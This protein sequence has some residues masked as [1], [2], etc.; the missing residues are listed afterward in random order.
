MARSV[1]LPRSPQ[2]VHFIG[3][4]P[5][6]STEEAL[7][8]LSKTLPHHIRRLP[9]GEPATRQNF[10]YF[11]HYLF[12]PYPQLVIARYNDDTTTAGASFD[13]GKL[14]DV[15][16][17][18]SKLETGYDSAAIESYAI[19]KK[20]RAE[21]VV[22]EGV[23]FQVSI[24]TPLN[25]IC[26][27]IAANHRTL[28]EPYY[29][30]AL[31]RALQNIQSQIPHEDLAIQID[32]PY[33]FGLLERLWKLPGTDR[34]APWWTTE[35]SNWDELF[36]AVVDRI[37]AFAG[38]GHVAKDVELGFHFCY[39]DVQH[40]HFVEP[41]DMGLIVKVA[42]AVFPRLAEQGRPVT[43]FHAPVPKERDDEAYFAPLKQLIPLL[44]EG[45]TE[46]Y[47]G[48]V[49]EGDEEGTYRRIETARKMVGEE[50]SWGVASECGMGR[51]PRDR[52]ASI[53]AIM[54]T[55]ARPVR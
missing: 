13:D 28:V 7:T 50:V 26:S 49:R 27:S 12:K 1:S 20:L 45:G 48:L 32:C 36:I 35:L 11:Q 54:K 17:H 31:V 21:G 24:P 8:L 51:T 53:L 19:F 16:D 52:V 25:G 40:K 29:T 39:G 6:D 42:N 4:V 37:V 10:V 15:R 5:C 44:I 34:F 38:Q 18:L 43:F 2:G 33:E 9:D 22:P 55:V 47:L 30:A 23:R 46:L 41:K 3:S 14:K